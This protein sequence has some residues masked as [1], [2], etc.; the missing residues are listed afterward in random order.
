MFELRLD[1]AEPWPG[2][3]LQQLANGRHG[4]LTVLAA[5]P[6]AGVVDA[7]GP[8]GQIA[9]LLQRGL[10]AALQGGQQGREPRHRGARRGGG[11]EQQAERPQI[12]RPHRQAE[13]EP[14]G[15]VFQRRGGGFEQGIVA[16]QRD[17]RVRV[18]QLRARHATVAQQRVRL[19]GLI[20][21]A[22]QGAEDGGPDHRGAEGGLWH[23]NSLWRSLSKFWRAS[24]SFRNGGRVESHISR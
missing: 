3:R 7:I 10:A 18:G 5:R 13:F 15:R 23:K 1:R 21:A 24:Q 20:E 9:L 22:Q 19:P 16:G 11:G 12:G 8:E 17:R 6:D 2:R 4:K 14:D